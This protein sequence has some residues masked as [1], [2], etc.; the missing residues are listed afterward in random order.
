MTT[1][2]G[3]H[4]MCRD[5]QRILEANQQKQSSHHLAIK[6]MQCRIK[7]WLMNRITCGDTF[8]SNQKLQVYGDKMLANGTAEERSQ[9][10]LIKNLRG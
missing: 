1:G 2:G 8:P 4:Y 9:D 3:S 10:L 7:R 6:L 5:S